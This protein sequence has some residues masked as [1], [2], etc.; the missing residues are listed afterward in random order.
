[1][2]FDN[3]KT[4]KEYILSNTTEEA[5]FSYYLDISVSDIKESINNQ[6]IKIRN[7][8][9]FE[10][11]PSIVFT[12]RN[13][14]KMID[15][16]SRAWTGDCFHIA[17]NILGKNC[18]DGR[19]FMFILNHII[20]N[21]I[22]SNTKYISIDTPVTYI[23]KELTKIEILTKDFIKSDYNYFNQFNIRNNSIINT[24]VIQNYWI[25]DNLN[26]YEYSKNDPCYAY[27]LGKIQD[28]ILWKLYFPLRK[29]NRF[30]CNNKI[31]IENINE[32][33]G[34]KF[35]ILVKSQKDK[36]LLRQIFKD[37]N[38]NIVDVYSVNSE[39]IIIPDNI[40]KFIRNK[41][42]KIFSAFDNDKAGIES[43][44]LLVASYN[45]YPIF[46]KG[47][48]AYNYS[49][50]ITDTSRDY[51]YDNIL[52]LIEYVYLNIIIM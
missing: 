2:K 18:N 37:L 15:F 40:I 35:L 1:M 21:I 29:E 14:L 48:S 8:H 3:I 43:T 11:N 19:D 34:N 4:I 52:K 20:E 44:N 47:C 26:T 38:I 17:G 39:N 16:G 42:N 24:F 22:K 41:Y 9:R 28:T 27:Y 49:K 50:D 13:K 5:I 30:I 32:I 46:L 6:S 51:G 31:C 45:I 36:L 12:Y 25:N 23:P 33:K 7:K 10:Q